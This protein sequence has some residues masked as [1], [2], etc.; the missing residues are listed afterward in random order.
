MTATLNG[1]N[2][3]QEATNTSLNQVTSMVISQDN[4]L[5]WIDSTHQ[6]IQNLLPWLCQRLDHPQGV[7]SQETHDN[8]MTPVSEK[9]VL[10]SPPD[11]SRKKACPEPTSQKLVVKNNN[12]E[13]PSVMESPPLG[14][15]RPGC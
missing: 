10:I 4:R 5:Q 7:V 2:Q 11:A 3:T 12:V 9:R 14:V 6:T 8:Q 13:S 15:A 1:M